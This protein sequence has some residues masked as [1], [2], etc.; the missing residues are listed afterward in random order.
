MMYNPKYR[1]KLY[2]HKLAT[3][4]LRDLLSLAGR[5]RTAEQEHNVAALLGAYKRMRGSFSTSQLGAD[6]DAIYSGAF[7]TANRVCSELSWLH[8]ELFP[9]LTEAEERLLERSGALKAR[10]EAS[11]GLSREVAPILRH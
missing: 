9:M 8:S 6:L 2:N 4:P 3:Q 5:P 11:Q 1:M 10:F 7:S